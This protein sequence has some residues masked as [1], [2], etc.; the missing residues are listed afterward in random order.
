MNNKMG[1]LDANNH[2]HGLCLEG[3]NTYIYCLLQKLTFASITYELRATAII[4]AKACTCT[5]TDDDM[6]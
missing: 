5:H 3:K 6:V 2:I 4:G 1:H